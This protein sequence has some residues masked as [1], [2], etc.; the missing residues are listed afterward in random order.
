MSSSKTKYGLLLIFFLL[1]SWYAFSLM[2]NK[3]HKKDLPPPS[4]QPTEELVPNAGPNLNKALINA[5]QQGDLA[6]VDSLLKQGASPNAYDKFLRTALMFA[7]SGNYPEVAK[8]LVEGGADVNFDS[9][10]LTTPLMVASL[11]GNVDMIRFLLEKGANVNKKDENS[12][13]A[14][15]IAENANQTEAAK[16]L[17]EKGATP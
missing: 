10:K 14:L 15:S 6:T 4:P 2:R 3:E 12:Q 8:R 13:T 9:M 1:L 7:I 16:L 17:R 5:S 11:K